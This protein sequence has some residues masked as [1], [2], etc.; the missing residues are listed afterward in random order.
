MLYILQIL[1]YYALEVRHLQKKTQLFD[2]RQTMHRE[3]FEIF[4]YHDA[5]MEEVP[6]HH[7]DFYEV[8]SF[9]SGKVEYLVEGI[10]YTLF[11]GDLLLIGP[12]DLHRP[13]VA[14]G[15]AYERIVLWINAEYL[16]SLLPT[17]ALRAC[18]E[19]GQSLYHSAHTPVPQLML[20]LAA[21]FSELSPDSELSVKGLFLQLMGELLRLRA[22][23]GE[24]ADE[25]ASS[26]PLVREVLHY[27]SENYREE[28]SLESLAA[29]FYVSK[30]HLSHQFSS[31]VGVSV[32][33]YIL[34]KR[35]QNAKQRLSEGE[36]PGDVCRGCGFQDYTNFYRAFRQVYGR[37]PM[38]A[39]GR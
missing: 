37:S 16:D 14:P 1:L 11:P 4:H 29:R 22:S 18:F 28:L 13:L 12:M 38:D 39:Q 36:S 21:E 7:H 10:S 34:L 2:P 8:Y 5:K 9:L 20:R 26:P 31:A 30:Y 35:L 32:Y 25:H 24:N 27:I 19:S 15:E 23:A 33:R 6:L 17:G 3:D